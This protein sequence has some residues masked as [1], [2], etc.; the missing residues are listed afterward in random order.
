M[1]R[2]SATVEMCRQVLSYFSTFKEADTFQHTIFFGYFHI[3]K[4]GL[5]TENACLDFTFFGFLAQGVYRLIAK[6]YGHHI[7]FPIGL[8]AR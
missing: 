7:S 2:I 8:P 4:V 3:V 6:T 5:G 1:R